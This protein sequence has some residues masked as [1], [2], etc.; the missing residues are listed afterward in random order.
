MSQFLHLHS[1]AQPDI[2]ALQ[3]QV[4]CLKLED[5]HRAGKK[6]TFF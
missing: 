3:A 5:G 2:E 6:H 4:T 1:R